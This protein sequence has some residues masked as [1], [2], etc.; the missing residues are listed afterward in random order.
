MLEVERKMSTIKQLGKGDNVHQ[1][2]FN[3]TQLSKNSCS[4][5]VIKNVFDVNLHHGLIKV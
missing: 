4:R 1:R 2:P 3:I 5:N